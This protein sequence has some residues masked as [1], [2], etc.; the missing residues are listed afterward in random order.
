MA[1]RSVLLV[2]LATGLATLLD[3]AIL[4]VAVP[5]LRADLGAHGVQLQW[6][7]AIY[8]LTF[9]IALVPAGRLGDAY[10]RGPFLVAGLLLFSGASLIGVFASSPAMLVAARLL[11]GIGAG[12]ANPQ[13]I[14]LLQDHFAGP[15]RARALGAYAA[16]ASLSGALAPP[17]GGLV[18]AL[19]G[20][21]LGWRIVLAVNLP[22][23]IVAASLGWFLWRR[24]GMGRPHPAAG[25][26]PG[27]SGGGRVAEGSGDPVKDARGS[28]GEPRRARIDVVGIALLTVVTLCGLLPVVGIGGS[29]PLIAG[30][31]GLAALAV[32]ALLGWERRVVRRGGLPI[33]LPELARSRGFVLGTVVAMCWFGSTLGTSFAITVFLQEGLGLSAFVAG[34]CLLPSAVTMGVASTV[35][36]RVVGRWGRRSVTVMLAVLAV[37][38]GATVGAVW[39]LPAAA[40]PVA[41]AGSQLLTGAAGGLITAPN[42]ALSL[43][44]A[45]PG[46]NGLAAGFFQVAQRISATVCMAAFSGVLV[47][48]AVPGDVPGY[49]SGLATALWITVALSLVAVIASAAEAGSRSGADRRRSG[50][51]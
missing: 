46:A 5:A 48:G 42:Q 7:L 36:W 13:V 8:S 3:Q 37:V 50:S 27:E 24:R 20:P 31:A 23:G 12:T 43:A 35:A 34:L 4:N 28:G 26:F 2:C 32:G 40:L 51:G 47:A 16:V 38:T 41:L 19:A 14:G 22:F 39:W 21:G 25:S 6:I 9:G 49:R 18:L 10:G 33:L 30:W 29:G 17:I 44:F 45:P 1:Q 11:Q 15:L